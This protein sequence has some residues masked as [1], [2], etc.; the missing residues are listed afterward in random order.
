MN[1]ANFLRNLFKA[2]RVKKTGDYFVAKFKPNHSSRYY[3]RRVATALLQPFEVA[4]IILHSKEKNGTPF[5]AIRMVVPVAELRLRLEYE[6]MEKYERDLLDRIHNYYDPQLKELL[7]K[8]DLESA[9]KI[10]KRSIVKA[11]ALDAIR[12]TPKKEF[13]EGD[14]CPTGCGGK[15]HLEKPKNCSCHIDPPCG[16]C[17]TL[18]IVCNQCGAGIDETSPTN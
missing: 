4:E 6:E 16:E 2:E 10:A 17:S 5:V 14:L 11:F 18:Q 12:N 7:D 9:T 13:G 3:A 8:G 15:M 1:D